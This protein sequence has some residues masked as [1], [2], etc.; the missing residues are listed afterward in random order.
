MFPIAHVS[1][2][3]LSGTFKSAKLSGSMLDSVV[4][5]LDISGAWS[6]MR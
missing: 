4:L 5:Q 2:L 3:R 1:S 6:H